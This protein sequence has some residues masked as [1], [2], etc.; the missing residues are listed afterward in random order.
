MESHPKSLPVRRSTSPAC[1]Y[2]LFWCFCLMPF[3]GGFQDMWGQ[4]PKPFSNICCVA[5]PAGPD[6]SAR[7]AK[8]SGTMQGF[9]IFCFKPGRVL[10]H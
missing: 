2:L 3:L 9:Q 7:P 6:W 4:G 10:C 1:N 5:G 8:G